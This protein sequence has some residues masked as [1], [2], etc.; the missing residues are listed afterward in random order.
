MSETDAP[1]RPE[2]YIKVEMELEREK[3]ALERERLSHEREKLSLERI[4]MQAD[5]DFFD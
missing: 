2:A 1:D 3:I 5:S 4:K